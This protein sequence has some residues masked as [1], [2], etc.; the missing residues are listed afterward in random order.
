L[1]NVTN[2]GNIENVFFLS[3]YIKSV[4]SICAAPLYGI[5]SMNAFN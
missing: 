4:K 3:V 5:C 2:D 1:L